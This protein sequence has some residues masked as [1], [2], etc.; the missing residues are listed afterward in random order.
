[1]MN[2]FIFLNQDQ[3]ITTKTFQT[4]NRKNILKLNSKFYFVEILIKLFSGSVGPLR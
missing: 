4:K 3:K 1:M 2:F